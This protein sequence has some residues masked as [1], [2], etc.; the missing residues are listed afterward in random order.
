MLTQPCQCATD[1]ALQQHGKEI[2]IIDAQKQISDKSNSSTY[3]VYT[4]R[5]Q[6]KVAKRRY[7]DFDSFRNCLARL[8]PDVL[9]PPIPEKHSLTDYAHVHTTNRNKDNQAMVDKRRRM[10]QRF[11][12]RL[13]SHP[14]LCHEHVVHRFLDGG[15]PWSEI[16][17]SP[18]LSTLDND[19]SNTFLFPSSSTSHDL[20]NPDPKFTESERVAKEHA[21]FASSPLDRSQRRLLRRLGDLS[22]DYAEL[23]AAY[24]MLGL[25]ESEQ[26]APKI[27]KIGLAADTTCSKT[28]HLVHELEVDFAEHMQEYAQY[29]RIAKQVL[30]QRHL[31]HAQLELIGTSLQA[32]RT[33]L[34]NLLETED[35]AL[36]LE[37]DMSHPEPPLPQATV[38]QEQQQQQQ[39]H[40]Q[41][42]ANNE[43]EEDDFD[44]RSIEDGFAA[45]D[46]T[47]IP[48]DSTSDE[49]S[50]E[51]MAYPSNA[52]A[53]AIRAS[54]DRYRKWS[55]PRKLLNA[56]SYTIQGMMDV[57]P[58]A[59]RRNQIAKLR[60]NV[61]QLESAQT[62][63][64]EE[65][66]NMSENIQRELDMFQKQRTNELRAMMVAYAR[67]HMKYCEESVLAWTKVRDCF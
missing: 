4:I 58:E 62:Q 10:L 65:L 16:L 26:V 34:R 66:K 29:T 48:K 50:T 28:Q 3:I 33:S 32:K 53:S 36:R 56:M 7:S 64:R 19:D 67:I 11:L 25:N 59:T 14:R 2:R 63:V 35:K 52:S 61:K 8:Y 9:V 30:R 12:V 17:T 51:S 42:S 45:I 18:P 13:A 1:L 40:R 60:E 20:K 21:E 47:H 37:A 31:K 23:G 6:D 15:V 5:F 41:S 27:E 24:N 46:T 49:G 43:E 57:D 39:Q 44:T 22:N 38:T 55:S 54:R